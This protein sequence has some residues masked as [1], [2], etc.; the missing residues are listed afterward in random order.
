VPRC[1][2]SEDASSPHPTSAAAQQAVAADE[3]SPSRALRE[4][5]VVAT[6]LLAIEGPGAQAIRVGVALSVVA[7]RAGAV[8]QQGPQ[9]RVPAFRDAAQAPAARVGWA[10]RRAAV[11]R[12][13]VHSRAAGSSMPCPLR[14]A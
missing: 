5:L 9:V 13:L 4:G 7:H 8:D 14:G 1:S 10:T 3:P 12:F 11:G 2:L 6:G